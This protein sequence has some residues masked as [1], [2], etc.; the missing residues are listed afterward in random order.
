MS[1][2]DWSWRLGGRVLLLFRG[3][4]R[5]M[6]FLDT[7][8]LSV[9]VSGLLCVA[10]CCVVMDWLVCCASLMYKRV[11]AD[12]TLLFAMMDWRSKAFTTYVTHAIRC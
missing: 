12:Q 1:G 8:E 4:S 10:L 2:V 5:V 11:L 7:L 3:D 6:S 9:S